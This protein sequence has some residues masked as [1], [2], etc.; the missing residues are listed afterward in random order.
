MSEVDALINQKIQQYLVVRKIGEGGM[1]TVYLGWHPVLERNVAIKVL[2]PKFA[3]DV[4]FIARFLVEARAAGGVSHPNMITVHDAGEDSGTYFIV[5]EYVDGS[6]LVK[7]LAKRK[8]FSE[9]EVI[10]FGLR[11][12][13]A[14][15]AAHQLHVIHRDVKPSNMMLSQKGELKIGDLGL[16]K[17][18]NHDEGLT[19]TGMVIGSAGYIS[20]EQIKHPKNVD[21]RTDIY[22]LGVSLYHIATGKLPFEGTTS[23]EVMSK[24]LTDEPVPPDL[25]NPDL[26][27]GICDVL[28][29]MMAKDVENRYQTMDE[30]SRALEQLEISAARS[31][32]NSNHAGGEMPSEDSETKSIDAGSLMTELS[33][34]KSSASM[35]FGLL[36]IALIVIGFLMWNLFPKGKPPTPNKP[37]PVA[38]HVVE[39][40]EKPP[41]LSPD[42]PS[43]PL[44]KEE[45]TSPA[46]QKPTASAT[47]AVQSTPVISRQMHNFESESEYGLT[48]SSVQFFAYEKDGSNI[49]RLESSKVQRDRAY[50]VNGRMLSWGFFKTKNAFEGGRIM[51]LWS[52]EAKDPPKH[53]VISGVGASIAIPLTPFETYRIQFQAKGILSSPKVTI[54]TGE[55]LNLS[56]ALFKEFHPGSNWAPIEWE[57]TAEEGGE[58]RI[59]FRVEERGEVWIDQL[60][61]EKRATPSP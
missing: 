15:S 58:T 7:L 1:G 28:S 33:P 61:I 14:L 23:V 54:Y 12:A 60:I 48:A 6:N 3:A 43:S 44:K 45:P 26:S 41:T 30:V 55:I 50:D 39:T 46:V 37:A 13:S 42:K 27:K 35:M 56:P 29:K 20:P 19:M 2:L 36:G 40:P 21:G 25:L 16:A 24:H 5:M 59:A 18:L 22:S 51:R 49:R 34:T 11:A 17:Q 57:I 31:V 10:H 53:Q 4:D 38:N 47:T 8:R 32:P 52:K 9:S